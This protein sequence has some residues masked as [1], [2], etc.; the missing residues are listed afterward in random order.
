MMRLLAKL[1]AGLL[2]LA[3]VA[4]HTQAGGKKRDRDI[5]QEPAEPPQIVPMENRVIPVAKPVQRQVTDFLD[6]TGRTGAVN[7]VTIVPRVTGYLVK[8]IFKEGADVRRGDLLFEIDPRPYQAQ[9]DAL[10]AKL[11]QS[12]ASLK[13]AKVTHA[14]FRELAKKNPATASQGDLDQ[15]QSQEEQAVASLVLA[16]ANLEAAKLNLEWTKVTAPIDGR[17]SRYYFTVGNLVNQDVTKLSTLVSLDPMFV[18]FDM[19][20]ASLLRIKRAVNEG[21]TLK[22]G[23]ETPVLMGLQ[24]EQ[25]FPHRGSLNFI[26]NQVNPA[27]GSIALRGV[28]PNPKPKNGTYLFLPGMFARVRLPIGQPRAALL[29]IDRA[30]MS[31]QGL[32]YVYVVNADNQVEYR[33]VTAGAIQDDGLRV[34]DQGLK[35]DDWVVI[36]GLAQVRPRL[37]VQP[38]RMPMPSVLQPETNKTKSGGQESGD[39]NKGAKEPARTRGASLHPCGCVST[40]H[41]RKPGKAT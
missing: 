7:A 32:K 5:T 4:L 31:D 36:G 3:V 21:R 6:F 17:I 40:Q 15:Y 13:L 1:G 12:S 30:L 38:E 19:D 23:A 26:D 11:T 35:T 24:G 22:A 41:R 39:G 34:I 28:F 16:Q 25:G 37:K 8:T 9:V 2:V 33:R 18:C 29:V 14:R 10:N 20:E 27:T